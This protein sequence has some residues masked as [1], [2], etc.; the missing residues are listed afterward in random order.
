MGKTVRLV[1]DTDA[2]GETGLALRGLRIDEQTDLLVASPHD[3]ALLA[4][5]IIEHQNGVMNIGKSWDELEAIGGIWFVR[6]SLG[7]LP[8]FYRRTPYDVLADDVSTEFENFSEGLL[9]LDEQGL[10]KAVFKR[11]AMKLLPPRLKNFHLLSTGYEEDLR[12]ICDR[13]KEKVK[14]GVEGHIAMFDWG[15]PQ[16]E[17]LDEW[18][19]C[20]YQHL[21]TGYRLAYRRFKG[22]QFAANNMFHHIIDAIKNADDEFSLYNDGVEF[23]LTYTQRRATITRRM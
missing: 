6:G 13:A 11:E 3:P 23:N 7:D 2:G 17:Y 14:K 1:I 16:G 22:D 20:A 15:H 12:T 8:N 21:V 4:H 18:F 5:D 9:S 19:D 10:T